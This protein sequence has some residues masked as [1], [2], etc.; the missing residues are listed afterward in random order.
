MRRIGGRC[1]CADYYVSM[2]DGHFGVRMSDEL[3]AAAVRSA[4]DLPRMTERILQAIDAALPGPRVV[5]TIAADA[6]NAIPEIGIG[7]FTRPDNG[8]ITVSVDPRR[9]VSAIV[10]DWLPLTLAHELITP[11]GSCAAPAMAARWAKP[12]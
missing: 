9:D 4:V 10:R 5:I 2:V 7:G 3:V 8:E 11:G 1:G 6:R 12:S